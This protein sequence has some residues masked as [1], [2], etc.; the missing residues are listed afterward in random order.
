MSQDPKILTLSE[1]S[2]LVLG[3]TTPNLE[4]NKLKDKERIKETEDFEGSHKRNR[5]PSEPIVIGKRLKLE[6]PFLY[7][8]H[9]DTPPT[10][11]R[12]DN[13]RISIASDDTCY[14]SSEEEEDE[15]VY[16][17]RPNKRNGCNYL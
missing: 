17:I 3:L 1:A 9:T 6:D 12:L 5:I 11:P 7:K 16:I 14:I 8:S 2:R 13:G 4:K 10:S 15:E